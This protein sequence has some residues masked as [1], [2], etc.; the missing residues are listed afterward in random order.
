MGFEYPQITQRGLSRNQVMLWLQRSQMFI[1]TGCELD[2][3]SSGAQCFRQWY[4][5]PFRSAGA[6]RNLFEL[7][8]S[9]K[10]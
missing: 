5:N 9:I 8:R 4:A 1:E 3:R 10:Q 2:P 6:R 7:A